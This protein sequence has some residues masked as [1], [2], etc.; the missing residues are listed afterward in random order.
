[1]PTAV[2]L[3]SVLMEIG[4]GSGFLIIVYCAPGSLNSFIEGLIENMKDIATSDMRIV[5][6][7][8]FNLDKILEANV[9]KINQVN[10]L[11]TL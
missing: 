3:L 8:N 10:C 4:N 9:T 11:T 7:G 5:L 1:M 2:E 6:V